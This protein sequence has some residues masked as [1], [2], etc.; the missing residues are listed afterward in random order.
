MS[1]RD[2]EVITGFTGVVT[3]L[4]DNA[5]YLLTYALLPFTLSL[6]ISFFDQL[7]TG[8]S[9]PSMVADVLN[10]VPQALFMLVWLR[11]L[12]FGPQDPRVHPLPVFGESEKSFFIAVVILFGLSILLVQLASG[13]LPLYGPGGAGTTGA[14]EGTVEGQFA[15]GN[16]GFAPLLLFFASLAYLVFSLASLFVLPARAIGERY[17]FQRSF[18]QTKGIKFRVFLVSMMIFIPEQLGAGIA[19]AL[20]DSISL[21]AST[22]VPSVAAQTLLLY[23]T[24]ALTAGIMAEAFKTVTGWTPGSNVTTWSP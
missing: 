16:L 17:S 7:I 3:G 4:L 6:T 20:I 21:A 8:D 19:L 5:R 15:Q 10:L 11:L 1:A 22:F 18:Q 9:M 24:L 12:L 14:S 13:L 2:Y 23:L